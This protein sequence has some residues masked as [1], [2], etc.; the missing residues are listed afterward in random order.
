[1][2]A[3]R[4]GMESVVSAL[5]RELGPD[6]KLSSQV[7]SL[8]ETPNLVLAVPPGELARLIRD[9]DP[10]SARALEGVR[11]SPLITI[12]VFARRAD[13]KKGPPRGV[14]VLIPRNEGM[15]L[16]GVLF[17]SS[18]FP[19]RVSDPEAVSLTVMLGGTTDPE[20]LRLEDSEILELLHQELGA[21]L[22]FQGSLLH[23][24]ITRWNSAI[25]VYSRDLEKARQALTSGFCNTPGRVVFTNYSGEVSIRGLIDSLAGLS[26]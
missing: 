16:L 4:G 9:Q 19:E 11:S 23:A 1:M 14:G 12:T 2:M 10:A 7:T 6:L 20:A 17:N 3:P 25:P 24:E 8:P 21:L 13:F 22:G 18:S 5:I 26:N 15:R